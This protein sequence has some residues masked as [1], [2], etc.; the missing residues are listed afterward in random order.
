M[1]SLAQSLVK[2]EMDTSGCTVQVFS[3][4]FSFTYLGCSAIH[5]NVFPN[6]DNTKCYWPSFEK[7]NWEDSK[8][9]CNDLSSKGNEDWILM[10]P[11]NAEEEGHLRTKK[12]EFK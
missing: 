2:K 6:H 1:S 3:P 7:R 10:N 12:Q 9:Y 5:S 4:N 11:R 8:T